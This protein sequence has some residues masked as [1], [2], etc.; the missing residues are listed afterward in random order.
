MIKYTLDE[1]TEINFLGFQNAQS[2]HWDFDCMTNP[3]PF[4]M[5]EERDDFGNYIATETEYVWSHILGALITMV[6]E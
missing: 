3:H 6:N 1:S 5:H 4:S 2:I